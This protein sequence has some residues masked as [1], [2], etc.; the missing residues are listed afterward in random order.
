MSAS[1]TIQEIASIAGQVA[2]AAGPGSVASDTATVVQQVA[3]AIGMDAA[4][5]TLESVLQAA[6]DGQYGDQAEKLFLL[7]IGPGDAAQ[8]AAD[9]YAE[10]WATKY[11]P[12]PSP[13][14]IFD[15]M[16]AD[17]WGGLTH[18]ARKK[19]GGFLIDEE[20]W[21]EQVR[22]AMWVLSHRATF[23]LLVL[24]NPDWASQITN[25]DITPLTAAAS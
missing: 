12:L 17:V 20:E 14:K 10:K 7:Q 8:V 9:Q 22:R 11:A 1:V 24:K 13:Q 21:F 19:P 3:E 16:S 6:I 5:A 25:E 15:T 18:A 2:A 23:A 4:G